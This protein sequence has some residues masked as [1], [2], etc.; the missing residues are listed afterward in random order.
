MHISEI[1]KDLNSGSK[2]ICTLLL[3][4]SQVMSSQSAQELFEKGNEQYK[5]EQY[6]DAIQTYNQIEQLSVTS[7]SLYYNLG[8]CYYKL[9][10]VA[11]SIYNYEKALLIDPLNED[12]KNNLVFAKRLAIDNIEALPKS[13]LQKVDEAVVKKLSYNGWAIASVVL[14]VVGCSLF[15]LFYFSFSPKNKRLFFVTSIICF[16]LLVTTSILTFKEYSFAQNNLEA[17]VFAVETKVKNAPSLNGET[18]FT[19]HEGTK[20]KVLDTI[21]NWKKVKIDDGKIGWITTDDLK[22]LR[23]F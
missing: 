12:A 18:V 5:L 6:E 23:V 15:M 1:H 11:P 17:I 4:I 16:M 21:D 10:R 9:N 14:S 2:I 20:V 7:S 22:M 13:V 3:L 8:N 19:L